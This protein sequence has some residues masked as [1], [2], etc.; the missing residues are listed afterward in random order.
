MF[1][2]KIRKLFIKI[3]K[4]WPVMYYISLLLKHLCLHL[5]GEKTEDTEETAKN[6]LACK[7]RFYV[8]IRGLFTHTTRKV[9]QR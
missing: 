8:P 1:T 9:L 7:T 5:S 3:G 6:I 2:L 4:E